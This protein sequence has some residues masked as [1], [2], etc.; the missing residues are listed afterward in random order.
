MGGIFE[1]LGLKMD[2]TTCTDPLKRLHKDYPLSLDQSQR[3]AEQP[4]DPD[5]EQKLLSLAKTN[6]NIWNQLPIFE[7]QKQNKVAITPEEI[8]QVIEQ[9]SNSERINK[10]FI[11]LK[12]KILNGNIIM[13]I[14]RHRGTSEYDT[15]F[16]LSPESQQKL[17]IIKGKS[18]VNYINRGSNG[19]SVCLYEELAPGLKKAKQIFSP[20]Q[21]QSIGPGFGLG[22]VKNGFN[23]KNRFPN[24]SLHNQRRKDDD[25]LTRKSN[26]DR[27]NASQMLIRSGD[28]ILDMQESQEAEPAIINNRLCQY[29][30]NKKELWKIL[31]LNIMTKNTI[32]SHESRPSQIDVLLLLGPSDQANQDIKNKNEDPNKKEIGY[33]D[34]LQMIRKYPEIIFRL[35]ESIV[36]QAL[37]TK[38]GNYYSDPNHANEKHEIQF[39]LEKK[40][41]IIDFSDAN[42][43]LS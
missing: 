14:A 24:P 25:M 1:K 27:L 22:A 31:E 8:K 30:P 21:F 20:Q 28:L 16:T 6:P 7:G 23:D 15:D 41:I 9:K 19:E 4:L 32:V 26:N 38:D 11:D 12:S 17:G 37:R 35:I 2:Q 36:P 3:L 10:A 43:K 42:Y 40:N 18:G 33:A 34:Y 29:K 13:S 39:S 5:D